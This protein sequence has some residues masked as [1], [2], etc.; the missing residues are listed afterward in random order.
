MQSKY[1]NN[2]TNGSFPI[3]SKG[4][5]KG[6]DFTNQYNPELADLLWQ[7]FHILMKP[8]VA[9][10]AKIY[11]SVLRPFLRMENRNIPIFRL[12]VILV[13]FSLI[14]FK[15]LSFAFTVSN[16]LAMITDDSNPLA[17]S[18]H[19]NDFYAKT[20]N[21]Y[22]PVSAKELNTTTA[23]EYIKRHKELA[24][25]EMRK[26]G[27]PASV[28]LA[29]ALIESRA[30]NSRLARQNK[31]HFGIK[32]FSK[33][34]K[35]GHCTNHF[36]DHHKDFFRN[37]ESVWLSYRAHSKLLQKKRYGKLKSYGKDYKKWSKG[38]KEAGYATDKKYDKKLIGIIKKYKLYQYDK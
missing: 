12:S 19:E 8:F 33:K 23:S 3:L 38:L 17:I 16:P 21:E 9:L 4:M 34:C 7:I 36:D 30:G 18:N 14:Y 6:Y 28:T 11:R 10:R 1:T 5:A 29:Q 27:I 26:Y 20:V 13:G 35:K 37:Y 15:N 2:E 31:N 22:A 24:I 25:A 32:C